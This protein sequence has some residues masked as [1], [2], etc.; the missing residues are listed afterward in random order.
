MAF[1]VLGLGVSTIDY[2]AFVD[3]FPSPDEKLRISE[4]CID[5]GGNCANTLSGLKKLGINTKIITAVGNDRFA[6][7][8]IDTLEKEGIDI[9]NIT[10]KN[11]CSPFSLLL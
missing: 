7:E 3:R 9:N 5:G 6:L 4:L 11:T 10:K 8:I 1:C 2:I